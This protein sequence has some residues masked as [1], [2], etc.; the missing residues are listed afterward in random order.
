MNDSDFA[1]LHRCPLFRSTP[2][3]ELRPRIER[4]PHAVSDYHA[5]SLIRSQ[6]DRYEELLILLRGEVA[7]EFRTHDGRT[8][9]VETLSAPEALAS[10]FLFSPQTRLPVDMVAVTEVRVFRIGRDALLAVAGACPAVLER[11]LE[12]IAHRTEFLA[13]KLRMVQFETLRERVAHYLLDQM[14][15]QGSPTV[16]LPVAKKELADILGSARQSVFRC[17]GE[18]EEEH[19]I[20]QNG[21]SVRILDPEG[22]RALAEAAE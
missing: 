20:A 4:V 16:T 6:G 18:L 19:I 13:T 22:L 1:L 10:A 21:R 8:M 9:R 7:G 14:N 15:A 11:L 3:S 17:L 12:D 5:D 2:A